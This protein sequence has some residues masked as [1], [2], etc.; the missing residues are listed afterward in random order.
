MK[1]KMKTIATILL[2]LV[3]C[4]GIVGATPKKIVIGITMQGNQSGF[5]QYI[6]AGME[7]ALL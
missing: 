6:T 5:I 1:S 2:M 4:L 3:L 7:A